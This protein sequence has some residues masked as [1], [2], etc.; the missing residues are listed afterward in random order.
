MTFGEPVIGPDMALT[1]ALPPLGG[2]VL[3]RS[4]GAIEHAVTYDVL[5]G[6]EALADNDTYYGFRYAGNDDLD[7]WRTLVMAGTGSNVNDFAW[8]Y[9]DTYTIGQMNNNQM[10]LPADAGGQEVPPFPTPMVI[11]NM[12]MDAQTE[13]VTL[14]TTGTNDWTPT[15]WYSTNLLQG[16]PGWRQATGAS[17]SYRAG[18]YTIWI[19]RMND[20]MPRF[21]RVSA[22]PE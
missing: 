11:M 3:R 5:G 1:N 10:L 8:A 15:A 9:S 17:N 19:P 4:M 12:V 20:G 22:S 21:Y 6:G 2:L 14:T 18:E 13:M 16:E 7:Y